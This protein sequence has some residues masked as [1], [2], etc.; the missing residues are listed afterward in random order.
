M[1]ETKR[2][3]AER[4]ADLMWLGKKFLRGLHSPEE[5]CAELNGTRSY[6]L[7]VKQIYYD[8]R[9]LE[10]R[11]LEDVSKD[12]KEFRARELQGLLEQE[13]ELWS[14]WERSKQDAE[15]QR[16]KG[17]LAKASDGNKPTITPTELTKTKEGQCGDPRY[18]ALILQIREQRAK[19]LALYAPLTIK[20]EGFNHQNIIIVQH[21]HEQDG[22]A[23]TNGHEDRLAAPAPSAD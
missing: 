20:G 5:L 8:L 7:S 14:E 3:K 23:G 9:A 11:W 2:T 18:H 13:L 22:D 12:I 6:Q 4:A 10:R 17:T 16:Q 21:S 19:L 15:M 1:A